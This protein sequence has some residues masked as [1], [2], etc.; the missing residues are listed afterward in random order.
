M[1]FFKCRQKFG[2]GHE[3][4]E[5]REH[6]SADVLKEELCVEYDWSEHYRGCDIE[7]V[8]CPPKE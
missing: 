6:Y 7:E 4:W 3:D 2:Y 1:K 8:E 5:Y